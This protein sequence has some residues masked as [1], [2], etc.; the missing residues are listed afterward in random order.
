MER[1]C[2]CRW[3]AFAISESGTSG[4][5]VSG[6]ADRYLQVLTI[7]RTWPRTQG[8]KSHGFNHCSFRVLLFISRRQVLIVRTECG[9][10]K[11]VGVGL[12]LYVS[13][14]HVD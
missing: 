6:A 4:L 9:I 14:R 13:L 11:H 3:R 10:G 1:A 5:D 12:H 8:L 7:I 2:D